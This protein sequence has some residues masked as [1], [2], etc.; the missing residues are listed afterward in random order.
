MPY[1]ESGNVVG[2]FGGS[3]NPP[4]DGHLM[5]A[6]TATKRLHL[7]Q[8][9]WMVTP[10]NPLKDHS[11]LASLEERMLMSRQL[12]DD[13]RIKITGFEQTIQIRQSVATIAH[14]IARNNG[15]R[16]VWV[17]GGD[18]LASFHHWHQWRD[19]AQMIPIAIIDRPSARMS[20]L[21][22]Q[23]AQTYSRF[24][25]DET[26][27]A[28]L[29]FMSPPAWVYIHGRLSTASSTVLRGQA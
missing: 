28:A 18:S 25:I 24:R 26:D 23:M 11:N 7:D 27:A 3:F 10:G 12:V 8:L 5:V 21:S 17:M 4:H 22:S 6:K 1:A 15:V 2:L 9:W 20:P 29:P 14:I 16:F 19:I 13:P